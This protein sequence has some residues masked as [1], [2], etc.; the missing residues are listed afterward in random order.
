MIFDKEFNI[1]AKVKLFPG[2]LGWHYIDVPALLTDISRENA[3]RGLVPI[4]ARINSTTWK[5]SMLPK[6][7]GTHIIPIK[8]QIRKD[9][10]ITLGAN[11][12]INITFI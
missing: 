12:S 7:D 11:I 5:T 9:E 6:G 3:I 4:K 2:N 10:N 1:T 8:L